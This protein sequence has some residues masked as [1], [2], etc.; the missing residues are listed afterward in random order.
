MIERRRELQEIALEQLKDTRRQQ[1]QR[2]LFGLRDLLE[3]SNFR[4]T[5]AP[6]RFYTE[7][8]EHEMLEM[9][10][11]TITMQSQLQRKRT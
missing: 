4:L 8:K 2:I 5:S 11:F 10:E 1:T 7:F 3:H 9:A 6:L